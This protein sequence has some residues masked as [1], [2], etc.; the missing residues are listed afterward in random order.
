VGCWL[1]QYTS[2]VAH[3]NIINGS[4]NITNEHYHTS[5]TS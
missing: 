2:S 5:F 1:Y 4:V 3:I